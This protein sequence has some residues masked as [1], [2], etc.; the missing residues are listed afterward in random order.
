MKAMHL[1]KYELGACGDILKKN[2]KWLTVIKAFSLT[3]Q[4]LVR[5]GG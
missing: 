1:Q 3:Q 4:W 2:D 5:Q